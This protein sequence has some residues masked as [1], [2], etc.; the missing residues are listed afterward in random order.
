MNGVTI[1]MNSWPVKY[2]GAM[3]AAGLAGSSIAPGNASTTGATLSHATLKSLA[4]HRVS[5]YNEPMRS[6]FTSPGAA[7]AITAEIVPTGP[8]PG[9][10]SATDRTEHIGKIDLAAFARRK[11][12]PA[13][14]QRRQVDAMNA[15]SIWD[16]VPS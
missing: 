2:R 12:D 16:E 14:R 10:S 6:P 3:L 9:E 1:K 4:H 7:K 15:S 13:D 8:D 5:A 11:G